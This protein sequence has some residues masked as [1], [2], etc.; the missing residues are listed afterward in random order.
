MAEEHSVLL[1]DQFIA[2]AS[3]HSADEKPCIKP[4]PITNENED[5]L[6]LEKVSKLEKGIRVT[7]ENK[8]DRSTIKSI[9]HTGETDSSEDEE[10]RDFEFRK[11]NESGRD[12]RR[13]LEK[14][15]S[16]TST[17]S[18][19]SS[20]WNK[21]RKVPENRNNN[22][23]KPVKAKIKP[24]AET[25]VYT[26]P[27]F[28]LRLVNPLISSITLQDRMK[29]RTAVSLS[30][31]KLHI[32]KINPDD[33]WVF[34]GAIVSKVVKTSQ[35]GNQFSI[36]TISDLHND[37]K[38]VAL[39]LFSGAHKNL[40]K[41]VQGTV[42]GVLNPTVMEQ[43]EKSSEEAT[44]SVNNSDR[45]MV[46]GHS[47][48]FGI[49]R[50]Q[51]KSGDPCTAFVNKNRCEYCIYHVK[52]EYQ[53]FSGRSD[54]QST[55]A[56]SGPNA[57]RNKVLGKNEVFYAGKSFTA[58]KGPSKRSTQKLRIKDEGILEALSSGVR[59]NTDINIRAKNLNKRAAN[60]IDASVSQRK[61]DLELLQKLST[62]SKKI[63]AADVTSG[64]RI[65]SV[66]GN[67]S[68]KTTKNIAQYDRTFDLFGGGLEAKRNFD[69]T[70]SSSVNLTDSKNTALDVI[71]KL[72]AKKVPIEEPKV[73]VNSDDNENKIIGTILDLPLFDDELEALN[74]D[75]DDLNI[76]KSKII[77]SP[78]QRT[79][80]KDTS[81]K[82]QKPIN[83]NVSN[84]K[85]VTKLQAES[86]SPNYTLPQ[87]IK[88]SVDVPIR[89]TGSSKSNL[90][91]DIPLLSGFSGKSIDLNTPIYKSHVN[92]AKQ[93]A[94]TY[95]QRNGPIAKVDPMNINSTKRKAPAHTDISTPAA[96]K[97]KEIQ[98]NEF[99]TQ[100][101]KKIMAATSKHPELLQK[102]DDQEQDKYFHNMEIKE[103]MEE[104]MLETFK[105]NCKA[106]KC[107][108]CKY[109]SF[110]ASDRCKAEK[111]P[112]KVYDTVK[113]F[114]KCSNCSNRTVC[115]T[116]VPLEGCQKCVNGKWERC[117]MIAERNVK[118]L[119]QLSIRGGEERYVGGAVTNA[120]INLMVPE[121]GTS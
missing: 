13:L 4:K 115:L 102:V 61:K 69:G 77:E 94:I 53:K 11:Y 32:A 103:K 52:S 22:L 88:K 28:G 81:K 33:D 86:K 104:K 89:N 6:F 25:S 37:L 67:N 106:V 87:K 63:E 93:N 108:K 21:V 57:L 78:K 18:A 16:S 51:K 26:D 50:S 101:F 10:Q 62:S 113:R 100:R 59:V 96:K 68:A 73:D 7:S 58:V 49:C 109:T 112:L 84:P 91:F 47:K 107:L 48:D 45:I 119:T 23:T 8:Q 114:F 30:R 40:W 98:E 56:G 76:D 2:A 55:F 35:K 3:E 34:A 82:I 39:F 118:T 120:N 111:H 99:M 15:S 70:V 43:K 46:L 24:V 20:S 41:T 97:L 83:T 105:V 60:K 117:A 31:M 12:I 1:L 75:S 110:S 38:T 54:L 44:L 85:I 42:V 17:E 74:Y 36:W 64:T 65:S 121:E 95:V 29:G 72:K 9:V 19:P 14:N 92:R 71:A 27:I 66:T 116:V 79:I 90:P 5:N 80:V